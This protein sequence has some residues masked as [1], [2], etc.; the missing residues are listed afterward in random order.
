MSRWFP[1]LIAVSV[2]A[3]FMAAGC[4]RS[5]EARKAAH[6]GRAEKYYQREKYPEAIVELQNVLRLDAQN[7]QAHYRLGLAHHRLGEFGLAY[8][9]LL[10]TQE[11]DG[12]KLDVRQ[13]LGEIYIARG[14]VDEAKEQAE[15]ILE[16]NANDLDALLLLA[17]TVRTMDELNAQI[18]AV[19][20]AK[21]RHGDQPRLYT[22]LGS[23]YAAKRDVA[24]A[25]RHFKEAVARDPKSI[26][27][28]TILGN[29][30]LSRRQVDAAEA[31]FKAAAGVAPVGSPSRM[32]LAEFYATTGKPDE[33][34]K[35]LAE[36][37]TKA[38]DFLPAWRRIAQLAFDER[39]YDEA[40][41]AVNRLLE[42]NPRDLEGRVLKG[43]I[44]LARRET[45]DAIQEFQKALKSEPKFTEARIQLATA[46]LQGGKVEQAKGALAEAISVTRNSADA[47]LMLAELNLRTNAARVAIGD[48]EKLVAEQPRLA[49]AWLMLA[50]AYLSVGQPG[51][52]TEI[53]R[54]LVAA[55]PKNPGLRVAAGAA[56]KAGGKP[57]EARKEFEAAL[58]ARPDY[59]E[60]L[61]QLVSLDMQAKNPKGALE[62]TQRQIALVPKSAAL[63]HL[64]GDVY[65]ANGDLS[66]AEAAFTH[67][68]E[69]EP[70]LDSAYLRLGRIYSSTEKLDQASAKIDELLARNPKNIRALMLSGNIQQRRGDFAAAQ[71][72]YEQVLKLNPRF[73][74]AANNLAYVLTETGG[75]KE[76]A[77]ELAQLAK[78]LIPDEPRVTD[79]LGWVLYKRGVHD[80]AARLLAESASKAPTDP[81]LQYHLGAATLRIGDRDT[82]RRALQVAVN[83]KEDFPGKDDARRLLAE[84]R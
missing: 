38:P 9:H 53:Y 1:S 31:E 34:K 25:E 17:A 22:M 63:H 72:T 2:L 48:L 27:A 54:K 32:R 76:R 83:A 35:V 64:L 82:A 67:A 66:K 36:I 61:A 81:L 15:Y 69:L 46:F 4:A 62:R 39:K 3:A 44:H 78:E 74:P 60:P 84:L 58:A 57:N 20:A 19:E 65:L 41:V 42:K 26:E 80:R 40:A 8:R 23:L 11:L 7:V 59:V 79:T 43:R 29:F 45:D 6:L 28:R 56:L 14:K 77:L 52:A 30:Y 71:R 70:G 10:K 12:T 51:K 18:A 49:R 68:I 33:A 24:T 16:R 73:G 21:A 13:K 50:G 55:A 75:D 37:T 47:R 5:P